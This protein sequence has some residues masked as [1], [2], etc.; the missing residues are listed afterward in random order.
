V[1]KQ[2]PEKTMAVSRALAV[3]RWRSAAPSGCAEWLVLG[4][5]VRILFAIIKLLL[6]RLGLLLV[7]KR[8]CS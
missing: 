1:T 6:E 4:I 3:R 7:S 5:L 8:Q 2:S